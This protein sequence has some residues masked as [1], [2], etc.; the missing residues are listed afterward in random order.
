MTIDIAGGKMKKR[1]NAAMER[2]INK[3]LA[4]HT[5]LGASHAWAYMEHC[6]VPP[7][8]ILRVLSE[9]QLRRITGQFPLLDEKPSE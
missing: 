5:L 8:V 2:D 7:H 3:A 4:V 6:K 1:S 9:P